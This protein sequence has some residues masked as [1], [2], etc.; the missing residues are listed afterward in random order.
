MPTKQFPLGFLWGAAVSAHQTEGGNDNSDWWSHELAT[1]TIAHEPSGSGW[2][3]Y[4]RSAEDWSLAASAGLNAVRFSIEWARIEPS[5]GEFSTEALDH[6]REVI[7]SARDA[8]LA[9]MV[10][11]HRFTNPGWFAERGGWTVDDSAELFGRY[12][13][14]ATDALGDLLGDVCTIN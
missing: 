5:P 13:R 12:S 14:A 11:L 3:S 10:T 9:P 2:D 1:G 4:Y 8:G 7:G 6:Y